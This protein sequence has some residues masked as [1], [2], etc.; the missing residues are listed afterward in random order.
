MFSWISTAWVLPSFLGPPVAAW[1]THHLGWPTVFWG[2]LPLVALGA[3]MMLPP[4][5]RLAGEEADADNA[6]SARPAALWAAGL[7]AL[8]AAGIQLAG[9][10]MS[11]L[12]L[13]AG[14]AGLVMVGVS[15]PNLMPSGFFRF[16]HG[17]APVILVRTLMAGAFFG[18][19]SFVPLMLVEQ[20]GLSLLLAGASLTVGSLGWTAGSWVQSRPSLSLRRDLIITLGAVALLGGVAMV[21]LVA[22]W[23]LW[24][25]LVAV[26]WT[27]A[28][29]GMGLAMS[30]TSVATMTLSAS[31]E[32]GRNASSLQFGEAFGGGLFVGVCGTVFAALHPTGDLTMTFSS[33]MA[34]MAVVS[35]LA[36]AV[37]LRTG[38]IANASAASE[39]P[40][41]SSPAA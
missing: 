24:V 38:P 4:V 13:A 39:A 37:S 27:F 26:S 3:V 19:E 6:R 20:R 41:P 11:P 31:G 33:V 16:G 2:I 1:L 17:L 22:W 32:Q 30:S 7:A 40:S 18:A 25:G 14:A 34:S 8:G 12:G 10:R 15:L 35:L 9:Q 36:V 29:L 21:A 28:G 5:F 23:Q